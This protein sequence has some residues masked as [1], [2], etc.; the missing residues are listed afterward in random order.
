MQDVTIEK[1]CHANKACAAG[2]SWAYALHPKKSKATLSEV[3]RCNLDNRLYLLWALDIILRNSKKAY[4]A[5]ACRLIRETPI[6]NGKF[7]FDLINNNHT[8]NS[9]IAAEKYVNGIVTD[10]ELADVTTIQ[11]M[12]AY[13]AS[14]CASADAAAMQLSI[15]RE[16]IH[17]VVFEKE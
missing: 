1:F 13:A 6:S 17:E 7:V 12:A 2:K 9:V 11:Y 8:I 3:A 10:I 15:I 4:V 14:A 16:T 5:F